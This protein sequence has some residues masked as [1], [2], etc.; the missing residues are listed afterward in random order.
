MASTTLDRL[1]ATDPRVLDYDDERAFGD[2]WWLFLNPGWNWDGCHTVHEPTVSGVVR[3]L[4]R[5]V[6]CE[7]GCDCGWDKE[8]QR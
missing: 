6:R 7:S 3:E 8:A 1:V 2:G 4:R 5:V